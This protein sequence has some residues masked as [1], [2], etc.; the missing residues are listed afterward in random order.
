MDPYTTLL[1]QGTSC[2]YLIEFI[3]LK[4]GKSD[5]KRYSFSAAIQSISTSESPGTPP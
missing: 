1:R 4:G 2:T 5:E 3:H